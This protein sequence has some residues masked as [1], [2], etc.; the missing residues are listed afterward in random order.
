MKSLN[1]SRHEKLRHFQASCDKNLFHPSTGVCFYITLILSM[2]Q[3]YDFILAQPAPTLVFRSLI[4]TLVSNFTW[5]APEL[6]AHIP[7]TCTQTWV[8]KQWGRESG[9]AL[10]AGPHRAGSTPSSDHYKRQAHNDRSKYPISAVS[11]S[12][13]SRINTTMWNQDQ[14][15]RINTS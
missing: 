11:L 2:I 14:S 9:E 3:V 8:V 4:E 13:V 12:K 15:Q 6:W 7:S 10:A 1:H 5:A